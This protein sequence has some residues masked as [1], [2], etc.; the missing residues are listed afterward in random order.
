MNTLEWTTLVLGILVRLA[1]PVGATAFLVWFL[2]RLDARWQEEAMQQAAN[3]GGIPVPISQLH[4]WDVHD[5]SP[6]KRATCPAYLNSN[7]SC[8]EAHRRNGQLQQACQGC[9]FRKMKL[10]AAPAAS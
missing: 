7:I 8:W 1:V 6:E 3:V 9:A 10:A 5:C 2:R 4:C